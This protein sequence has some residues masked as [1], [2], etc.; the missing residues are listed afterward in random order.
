MDDGGNG[1]GMRMRGGRLK[2]TVRRA[3]GPLPP[4][5]L[6]SSLYRSG[7]G[8]QLGRHR[9]FGQTSIC[10]LGRVERRGR[11]DGDGYEVRA[12][13]AHCAARHRA[14]TAHGASIIAIQEWVGSSTRALPSFRSDVHMPMGAR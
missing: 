1:M 5:A 8:A 3:T 10:P 14:L 6:Q 7:S 12:A 4:M 11:R 9:R 2:D 13:V